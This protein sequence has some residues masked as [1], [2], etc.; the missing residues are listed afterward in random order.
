MKKKIKVKITESKKKKLNEVTPT[1]ELWQVKAVLTINNPETEDDPGLEDYRNSIRVRCG[2]T[3]V[4]G[5][6]SFR[7]EGGRVMSK[8][9]IKFATDGPPE[10]ELK[11]LKSLISQ[12]KGVRSISFLAGTLTKAEIK[13]RE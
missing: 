1:T 13:W 11:R 8:L 5:I 9:R 4:D 10:Y 6:G 7:K 2:V 12:I 3:I